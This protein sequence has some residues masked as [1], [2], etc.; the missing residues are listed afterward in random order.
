MK[1]FTAL[2]PVMLS[3]VHAQE[4]KLERFTAVAGDGF[5]ELS[6]E[7]RNE[8]NFRGFVVLRTSAD[9]SAGFAML[10]SH[11][12]DSALVARGTIGNYSRRYIWNDWSASNDH[13]YWYKLKIALQSGAELFSQAVRASPNANQRINRSSLQL[14]WEWQ[15]PIPPGNEYNDVCFVDAEHGWIVGANNMILRTSDGGRSWESLNSGMLQTAA[16]SHIDIQWQQVRFFDQRRGVVGGYSARAGFENL[17][18]HTQD[19]GESWQITLRAHIA[20]GNPWLDMFFLDNQHGWLFVDGR[21]TFKTFDGGLHW[22]QI[23]GVPPPIPRNGGFITPSGLYQLCFTSP[24]TGWGAFEAN[25]IFYTTNS[26][27]DWQPRSFSLLDRT[28]DIFF[29]NSRVGWLVDERGQVY[30]TVD[31]G[32]TWRLQ[33]ALNRFLS[34]IFFLDEDTGFAL[35]S[36]AI[37]KTSD[38]G[39]S[40]SEQTFGRKMLLS[41]FSRVGPSDLWI[42]GAAPWQAQYGHASVLLHS[43]NQGESWERRD[44]GFVGDIVALAFLDLNMGR[45]LGNEKDSS[46]SFHAALLRTTNG[47]KVWERRLRFDAG[48]PRAMKISDQAQGVIAANLIPNG[49]SPPGISVFSTHNDWQNVQRFDLVG[50]EF[51][52][53]QFFDVQH[54][55]ACG[56]NG[57][58]LRTDNAGQA[59]LQ[60]QIET[61]DRDSL[62]LEHVHFID[63]KQGWAAAW[64]GATYPGY[65]VLLATTDGGRTWQQIWRADNFQMSSMVFVDSLQG[66]ASAN[67]NPCL[68]TFDGGRNWQKHNIGLPDYLSLRYRFRSRHLGWALSD[69]GHILLT[70]DGGNRWQS[71]PRV[72]TGITTLDFIDPLHGWMA[73]GQGRILATISGGLLRQHLTEVAEPQASGPDTDFELYQ[74]YPNPFNPTTTIRYRLPKS[75]KVT[76][77]IFNMLGQEVRK[78]AAAKFETAGAHSVSWDGKDNHGIVAATGIYFYRLESEHAVQQKKMILLH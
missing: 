41:G 46:G 56:A 76:L 27:R 25:M 5:V 62:A 43:Q 70:E 18:L 64:N 9:S 20:A 11:E 28:Y 26:G 12:Q 13:A 73:G 42:A 29:L 7:I 30:H 39:K 58:L 78:L 36:G 75:G 21:G 34:R 63:T 33:S 47:G 49:A 65:G 37:F 38:R 54:G 17:V 66:W 16:D 23:G 2:F 45:A 4:S 74:N 57:L 32:A 72:T 6:W 51:A 71:L 52:E 60:G 35:G 67:E 14:G 40:W 55:W 31:A 61:P 50:Y 15:N 24:D 10:A 19:G 3:C 59:W 68:R 53:I 8:M 44:Q 77:R 22:S 48:W 1:I 69:Q